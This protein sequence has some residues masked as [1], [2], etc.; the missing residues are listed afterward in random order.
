MRELSGVPLLSH[1]ALTGAPPIVKSDFHP[2]AAEWQGIVDRELDA[3]V[4]GEQVLA[5]VVVDGAVDLRILEY[6][7]RAFGRGRSATARTYVREV[8]TWCGFLT[9]RQSR[10][11][12]ATW[13]DVRAYQT[14][15]VYDQRNTGRVSPATWNKGLAAL[16]HFYSWAVN[17]AVLSSSHAP[18]MDPAHELR[19][20]FVLGTPVHRDP[21]VKGGYLEKNARR[22]RDRWVSASEYR[23]WRDIAFRSYSGAV[24]SGGRMTSGQVDI[25]SRKR[26][27]ARDWAFADLLWSSGLRVSEAAHLLTFEL[28]TGVDEDLPVIGKG[29]V[30]RRARVFSADALLQIRSYIDGERR[31]ALIRASRTGSLDLPVGGVE[32]V[33]VQGAGPH[34]HRIS[35]RDPHQQGVFT[36]DAVQLT[37]QQRLN[38]YQRSQEDDSDLGGGWIPVALWLNESGKPLKNV[39][40]TMFD[41]ANDRVSARRTAL[42]ITSALVNVTPHSLRFSFALMVLLANIRAI[43]KSLGLEFGSPFQI[44][45]YTEAFDHVRDL[46]GHSSTQTTIDRYLEPAKGIRRSR[47]FEGSIEDMWSEVAA[48]SPQ[49]GL[50]KGSST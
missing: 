44:G 24:D 18:V 45:R 6:S 50:G 36:L 7:R 25:K 5:L 3:G 39:W 48:V 13:D 16:R 26:N 46:L 30:F 11:D 32:L 35:I 1:M 4:P 12:L 23:A 28:P 19:D 34:G 49:V 29:S 17:S 20:P 38:L 8:M 10:W 27:S 15:R 42:G 47:V 22:S 33:D 14:W 37:Q 41:Q 9:S 21:S 40:S 43:D 31:R 2:L